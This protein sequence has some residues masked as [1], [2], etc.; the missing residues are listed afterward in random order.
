MA[1]D[2]IVIANIKKELSDCCLDA[3]INKIAQPE[4]DELLLTL[5]G[6]KGTVKLLLSASPSLPLIY[7][8]K[9]S[10][11]SP[12][13][14]PNF[15]MLLRK[16]V[17]AGRIVQI[18]QPELERILIF[19]IEHLDNLGDK[20]R[21]KL[22]VELM[23]K[24]SNIIFCT[25]DNIIL[26]SIKHV[27]SAVSSVREVLPGR[28]YF[29]PKQEGKC[30]P[31]TFTQKDSDMI[32]NK[33]VTV[34]KAIYTSL[35]GISPL[36][37]NEICYRAQIDGDSSTA[38]LTDTQKTNLAAQLFS[39]LLLI[40]ENL[41]TPT[42]IY[43]QEGKPLEFTSVPLTIYQDKKT[44]FCDSIS[45]VLQQ[46]YRQKERFSRISQKSADLRHVVHT[47]LE[48]ARKKQIIQEKQLKDTGKREKYKKY[49]ELIHIYGYQLPENT[50]GFEAYDYESETTVRIPLDNTISP[51][52]NAK[53]YFE[54]YSKLKR[55]LEAVT[56]QLEE[57]KAEIAHLESIEIALKQSESE[58]DLTEIKLE[59]SQSGYIKK[60][61][62]KKGQRLQVSKPYHYRSGDGF[63]IY[64]G[65]NN[66]QNEDV[67][68]RMATGNDWWFHAKQTPGSHVLVKTSTG[69]LPDRTF[70]EAA[71]LAAYYSTCRDSK[72]VE[73]D[74]LQKKHV[75]K[76]NKAKP[77]FVVYYTN[78][79]MTIE[80][81]IDG[82]ERIS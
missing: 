82:I 2:G 14:A 28:K 33:P 71:R 54:R 18:E 52:E 17:S 43:D 41:F 80:P 81:N 30:N 39:F 61:L 29:I 36:I 40:K 58:A 60:Q 44:V 74:Y 16:H 25:E 23:G 66:F 9:E 20:K 76:P 27:S 5:K 8:T 7:I 26:D 64:V 78:F 38:S 42:I 13:T 10:K 69:E 73:V 35:T 57:T 63:D 19:H 62:H 3:V 45:E 4:S 68:F 24:H 65:R 53:K 72:K 59:L 12:L 79:S 1:L 15:C 67:T 47:L 21:K 70:E 75:K 77:G 34:S 51:M 48:R 55:T 50:S 32:W 37:A 11:Q 56:E 6:K 31:L 22:I 49:G 46:Y